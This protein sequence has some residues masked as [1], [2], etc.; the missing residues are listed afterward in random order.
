MAANVAIF[1]DGGAFDTS[2][3]LIDDKI[4]LADALF[5]SLIELKTVSTHVAASFTIFYDGGT[6]DTSEVL[7]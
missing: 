2:F 5:K 4:I 7:A 6:F 1:N 3:V